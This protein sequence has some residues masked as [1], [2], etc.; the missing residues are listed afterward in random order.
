[1]AASRLQDSFSLELRTTAPA[2]TEEQA[3]REFV[4]WA[5]RIPVTAGPPSPEASK[6]SSDCCALPPA[7]QPVLRRRRHLTRSRSCCTLRPRG[8]RSHAMPPRSTSPRCFASGRASCVRG[9]ARR[10]TAP[11]A[12]ARGGPGSLDP[13]ADCLALASL[14]VPIV[15]DP[16]TGAV[17]VSDQ[18]AVHVDDSARATLL[19]VRLLAGVA[20]HAGAAV[21]ACRG[22]PRGRRRKHRRRHRRTDREGTLQ[23]RVSAHVSRL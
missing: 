7:S 15:R 5:R 20:A 16:V 1:M 11:S 19:D 14:Q 9:C 17:R 22:G 4:A 21:N 6:R 2:A 12:I 18:A 3:V 10:R 8:S 13:D 23:D